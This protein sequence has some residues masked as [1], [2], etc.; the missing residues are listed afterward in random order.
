MNI[1]DTIQPISNKEIESVIKT[2]QEGKK[3]SRP[4]GFMEFMGEFYQ[5]FKA[6]LTPIFLTFFQKLMRKEHCR[7][8]SIRLAL[9]LYKTDK[10]TTG[11]LKAKYS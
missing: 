8:N 1:R 10:N 5:T 7:I 11:K 6:N 9:P 3:I 4:D 2:F